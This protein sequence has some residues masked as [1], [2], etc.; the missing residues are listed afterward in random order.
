MYGI[1]AITSV[2]YSFAFEII[3]NVWIRFSSTGGYVDWMTIILFFSGFPSS[4]ILLSPSEKTLSWD[5]NKFAPNLFANFFARSLDEFPDITVNFVNS[6]TIKKGFLNFEDIVN[7]D[8]CDPHF[9]ILMKTITG[10]YE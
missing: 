10:N 5:F 3:D 4:V 2:P 6:S 1:T 9:A 8:F 7:Y